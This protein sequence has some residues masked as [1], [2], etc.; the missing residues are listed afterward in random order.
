MDT[1]SGCAFHTRCP[2]AMPV[3]NT[4]RPELEEVAADKW[5][6]CHLYPDEIQSI[7]KG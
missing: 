4:V 2:Y 1:P 3:C 7:D 6:A 5:V